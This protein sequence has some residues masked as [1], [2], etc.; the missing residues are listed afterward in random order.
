[1][2]EQPVLDYLNA[3]ILRKGEQLRLDGVTKETFIDIPIVK[4]TKRTYRTVGIL[5]IGARKPDGDSK[6]KA[7]A[8]LEKLHLT[9]RK[10]LALH[11]DEPQTLKWLDEGWIVKEVRLKTDGKTVDSQCYRM[12]YTYYRFLE[13]QKLMEHQT[14]QDELMTLKNTFEQIDITSAETAVKST[15][16]ERIRERFLSVCRPDALIQSELFEKAWPDQKRIK[17]LAFL[18]AI[19]Q[20]STVQD[21]FDWKE[22][23]ASYYKK[24]GGSKV[25]D[26]NK[27]DFLDLFEAWAGYPAEALGM[28]SLGNLT[29]VYFS[30]QVTG[31]YSSYHYGPVHAVTNLSLYEDSHSSEAETLWIVENRAILTRIAAEK[32]FLKDMRVLLVCCDGHV[33]SAHRHFIE[34]I[35][36]NSP[37]KQVIIWT[38]YDPDGFRIAREVFEIVKETPVVKWIGPA[39]E[40]LNSW[41]QYAGQMSAFLETRRME[42]EEQTGDVM[43]WKTWIAH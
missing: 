10:K 11:E 37:P 2:I 19:I 4:V 27:S 28:V 23:G 3:Y 35:L 34:Q 12:G 18:A 42:Q 31:T 16:Y 13:E 9:P 43:L 15:I 8:Q 6:S 5:T 30:G 1:M 40:I 38:D 29:P 39:G 7:G 32:D 21:R 14:R 24:I 36:R 22:I 20:I 25:F 33:R 17:F 26:R 41:T